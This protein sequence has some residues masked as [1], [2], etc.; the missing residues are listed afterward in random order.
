MLD[1]DLTTRRVDVVGTSWLTDTF[2]GGIGLGQALIFEEIPVGCRALDPQNVVVLSAGPLVGTAAPAACRLSISAMNAVTGGV[3]FSNTG[4]HFAPELKYAGYDAA[5][6]RG[7]SEQPVY[8]EIVDDLVRVADATQLWGKTTGETEDAIRGKMGDRRAR[9]LCIGPGGENQTAAGCVIVDRFRAGGR[10]AVGS[11]FGSKNLKAVAV[12]GTRAV[13]V[14]RPSTFMEGVAQAN[15][16]LKNS[17]VGRM[18]HEYGPFVM[19]PALN[20]LCH[21]PFRN[22]QDEHVDPGRLG[23]VDPDIF[24]KRHR[25]RKIGCFNCGISCD[26]RFTVREGTYAGTSCQAF[27]QNSMENFVDRLDIADPAA[28]LYLCSLCAALGLDIDNT[29]VVVAWAFECF[30]R[31]L[32]TRADTDGSELRWGDHA[33]VAQLIEKLAQRH[34]FGALL[35]LGVKEAARLVGPEAQRLASSVKGQELQESI[36]SQKGWA[37]GVVVAT[38]GGAHLDGAPAIET[39]EN[40]PTE[41]LQARFGNAQVGDPG[42]ME[43]KPEAVF[44]YESFKAL[45]DALGVCYFAVSWVAPDLLWP[46]DLAVLLSA[47]TGRDQSA[48]E[49]MAIGRKI[50]EL[51]K[52]FNTLHR[53]FARQDDLPPTRLLEEPIAS[54][55]RQGA[56]LDADEWNQALDRYYRLHGW[57]VGTGWQ[58]RQGLTAIGLEHVANRL[59][60][61]GRLPALAR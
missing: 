33:V 56:H 48:E 24:V 57:D 30:E 61:A 53:G 12:R 18:L 55:P 34:G 58:T 44:Y 6:I 45:V 49:L 3:N 17:Q 14:A 29:S 38:R 50:V 31:G 20:E 19:N 9:V 1:V 28:A 22:N 54:G 2:L 37:L 27:E 51:R 40:V 32:L 36:R 4:G 59:A 21:V 42:T 5:V 52:A 46:E 41:L 25:E 13:E 47:A 39:W 8:L 60:E 23:P 26:N 16:K 10:G 11:V 7:R 43:G 15:R 35:A